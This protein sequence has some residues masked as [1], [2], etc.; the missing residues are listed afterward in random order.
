MERRRRNWLMDQVEDW[1]ENKR[2][3]IPLGVRER[4]FNILL[5]ETS[6]VI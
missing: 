5:C 4:H 2:Y 3:E 1:K 6:L